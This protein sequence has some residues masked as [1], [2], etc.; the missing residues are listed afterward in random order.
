MSIRRSTVQVPALATMWMQH[1]F[2]HVREFLEAGKRIGIQQFELGHV[3]RPEMLE[4]I[5][6]RDAEFPS[7]HAPCPT[8]IG[9]GSRQGIVF[10]ALDEAKREAA[11]A[12]T[13]QTLDVAQRLGASAVVVHVGHVEVD[14]ALEKEMCRLYTAL[15]EDTPRFQA[16]RAQLVGARAEQAPPYL[17]AVRRSLETLVAEARKRGLRLGMENRVHYH[18][19]PTLEEAQALLAEFDPGALFYWHDAGHAQVLQNLG[20]ILHEAW[21]ETFRGRMLGIHL[22]D[23]MGTRDHLVCG[24]GEIDWAWIAGYLAPDTLRTCEFDWYFEPEHLWQG[25]EVLD[26]AG[27]L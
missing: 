2:S 14:A 9:L 27:C 24:L 19:I 15:E 20:F 25:V 22:H 18:E 10:S 26:A 13:V 17:D 23:V 5:T 7:I 21:L 4:G 8:T 11:V 16:L 3:V 1:R 12:L 6:R